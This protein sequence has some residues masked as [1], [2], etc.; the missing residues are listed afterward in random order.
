MYRILVVDDEP[1]IIRGLKLIFLKFN[2]F[3][4]LEAPDRKTALS[5]L[6]DTDVD[7]VLTDLLLPDLMDGIS[8]IETAKSCYYDPLVMVMT[9]FEIIENVVSAMQAG[10]DDLILK[11]FTKDE[12]LIRIKNL[13]KKKKVIFNLSVQN[14]VLK[15]AVQKSFGDYEIIGRSNHT[16]EIISVIN[17]VAED[18]SSTCL[19]T[20]LTGSGKELVARVIHEQS[21]RR[22]EPFVPVNCAAIPETLIESELFGHEKGAFTGAIIR[23]IG[24]FE[25]A[26]TGILFLDEIGDLPLNQQMRLL[27]VLEEKTFTRVGGN[28]E[29]DFQ[30]MV[31][32]AT[33]KNLSKCVEE[34]LFRE[35]LYYRI[36]IITISIKP[37]YKRRKDIQP[38]AKFFLKKL[39]KE[40]NKK[41]NFTDM[42]LK[43]LLHYDYPGNVRQLRNIVES[44]FVFTDGNSIGP[45]N[46]LIP[47]ESK[48]R[49]NEFEFLF[50]L[51]HKEAIRKFEYKYFKNL[52]I[53]NNDV[54]MD[55]AK[56]AKLSNEW[57]GKKI[58]QLGLKH[59]Y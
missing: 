2:D 42:A 59:E 47:S 38:L 26:G 56:Q 41:V 13:I 28:K 53:K 15:S 18:A 25:Q 14:T 20:G 44:A 17:K 12:L 22:N 10:A 33:N 49:D 51:S 35:D 30:A 52:I 50:E 16:K 46:I 31:L 39:N 29:I 48:D 32:S 3:E 1:S 11:G 45:E 58:K 55:A 6:R 7:L 8:I 54:L 21:W 57:L 24:K 43:K 40:R 9:G 19:I 36:N 4:I 23:R 27:R 37:L 5:I 34:G